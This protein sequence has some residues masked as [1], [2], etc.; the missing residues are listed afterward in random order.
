MSDQQRRTRR[1][2]SILSKWTTVYAGWQVGTRS[3]SD[4]VA[5]AVRDHRE[6]SLFLRAEQS[7][8]IGLLIEKGVITTEEWLVALEREASQ[9]SEDLEQRFPGFKATETG[10]NMDVQKARET[11]KGWPP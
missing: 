6:V 2:L 10:L 9:L 8:L 7:A 4:P 11:T 1:A 3:K 5:A